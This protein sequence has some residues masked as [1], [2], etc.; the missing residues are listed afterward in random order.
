M[1]DK[2]DKD[3]KPRK[4]RKGGVMMLVIVAVAMLAVGGGVVFGLFAAGILGGPIKVIKEDNNPKLI[5]KGE[6]D[7]YAPVA[8]EGDGGG[9]DVDGDGGSE[10]RTLYFTFTEDFTA[11]LK[12]SDRLIQIALAAS[13]RRDYRVVLWLKKHELAI[14]SAILVVLAD[15]PE[16]NVANAAGKARLQGRITAAINHVLTESEGFG[17]VDA[18]YFKT[19][20]VQ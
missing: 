19:F 16:S 14:R 6:K 10:Y 3:A 9:K 13:T 20:I 8:A 11:N 7:P 5:R 18:V 2:P 12:E 1:S 17:G 4:K 15:T